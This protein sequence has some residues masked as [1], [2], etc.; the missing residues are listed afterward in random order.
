MRLRRFPH[1]PDWFT[2]HAWTVL[3]VTE[4]WDRLLFSRPLMEKF[5]VRVVIQSSMDTGRLKPII[6]IHSGYYAEIFWSRKRSKSVG[7]IDYG[8]MVAESGDTK[9]SGCAGK[10]FD[11]EKMMTRFGPF[12]QPCF[13][14]WYWINYEDISRISLFS[15]FIQ[16]L[17]V[18]YV[19]WERSG[20]CE[21]PARTSLLQTMRWKGEKYSKV[22]Y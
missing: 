5:I 8:R 3:I 16:M 20:L 22:S 7:P 19:S 1:D 4:P 15:Y 9:C 2:P 11:A 13:R 17:H 21:N 12:H 10:I 14:Y 18:W 6:C